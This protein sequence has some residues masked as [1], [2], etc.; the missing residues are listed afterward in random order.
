MTDTVAE[1][2]FHVWMAGVFLLIAFAGFTPSYWTK[3]ASGTFI[4]APIYHLHGLLLSAW[5]CFYF[6]QT[7][8]VASGR[9]MNHRTWGMAG[10]ALFSVMACTTVVLG[11]NSMNI[12]DHEGFGDAGRRFSVVT[13]ISLALVVVLFAAAIANVRRPDVHKRLMVLMMAVLMQPAIGRMFALL[14]A[15]PGAAGPPPLLS[16]VPVAAVASL[17]VIVAIVHDWRTR[18][19]PHR[20]YLYGGLFVLVVLLLRI[21]IAGSDAWVAFAGALQH[22]MG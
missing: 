2:R 13:F 14:F 18:G 20:V 7:A 19:R 17:L 5:V 10:I 15:S 9:T 8:L 1:K 21:P 12:A 4:A 22:L 11:I 3:V 16:T 6:V